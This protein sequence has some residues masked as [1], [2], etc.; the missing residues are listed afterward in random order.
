MRPLGFWGVAG[1]SG[2]AGSAFP[3]QQARGAAGGTPRSGTGVEHIHSHT[4]ESLLR[5]SVCLVW[6]LARRG[7]CLPPLLTSS[8]GLPHGDA[9]RPRGCTVIASLVC[10]VCV[11]AL[12]VHLG[13]AYPPLLLLLLAKRVVPPATSRPHTYVPYPPSPRRTLAFFFLC[14]FVVPQS[15]CGPCR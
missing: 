2:A 5:C 3:V 4:H 8:A 7:R 9:R 15:A 13:R 10:L 1:W 14:I 12:S 6:S 11:V